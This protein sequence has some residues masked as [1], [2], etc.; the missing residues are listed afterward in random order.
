ML[1]HD[2]SWRG[3]HQFWLFACCRRHRFLRVNAILITCCLVGYGWRRVSIQSI[4]LVGKDSAIEGRIR[5]RSRSFLRYNI[6]LQVIN[7][8]LINWR[9]LLVIAKCILV[10]AQSLRDSIV[11]LVKSPLTNCVLKRAWLLLTVVVVCTWNSV[12]IFVSCMADVDCRVLRIHQ[13]DWHLA[14]H[15]LR[16][17]QFLGH[18]WL[19]RWLAQHLAGLASQWQLGNILAIFILARHVLYR[20]H[21]LWQK[22]TILHHLL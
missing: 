9:L 10:W 12:D 4:L 1:H 3:R 8:L 16:L 7:F 15:F 6:G 14:Y 5:H 22:P 2:I 18:Q 19:P 21:L 17:V 20:V 13:I 11:R